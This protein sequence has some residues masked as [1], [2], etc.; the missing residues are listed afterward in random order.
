MIKVQYL[1]KTLTYQRIEGFCY[2]LKPE[3][4]KSVRFTF[5]GAFKSTMTSKNEQREHEKQA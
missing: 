3:K 2:T 4:L 5:T 1:A